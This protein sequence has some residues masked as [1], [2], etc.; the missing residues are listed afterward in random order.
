MSA[1]VLKDFADLLATPELA[2]LG[3]GPRQGVQPEASIRD[4]VEER[5]RGARIPTASRQLVLALILLWH[6]H[7]DAAH[8]IAQDIGNADGSLVHAILHRREPDYGNAQYW[9]RR[10]G[11]H[12]AF[13]ELSASVRAL[14]ELKA[15]PDLRS[16]LIPNG[17]W[18]AMAMISACEQASRRHDEQKAGLLRQV[19]RIETEILLAWLLQPNAG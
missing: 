19:Q 16:A 3:P 15:D 8:A 12:P 14:P 9:F 7:F 17:K 4:R 1:P 13:T 5:L 18:D 6:D 2:A 11:D 10:V